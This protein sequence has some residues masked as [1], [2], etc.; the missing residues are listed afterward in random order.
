MKV[1]Y[2]VIIQFSM[3]QPSD[4]FMDNELEKQFFSGHLFNPSNIFSV[5]KVWKCSLISKGY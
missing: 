5:S 4:K 3:L 1:E 2:F